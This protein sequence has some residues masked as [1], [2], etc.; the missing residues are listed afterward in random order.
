MDQT[1]LQRPAVNCLTCPAN[2]NDFSVGRRV[3]FNKRVV[4]AFRDNAAVADNNSSKRRA[5][6][7][8]HRD[9][10]RVKSLPHEGGV[11]FRSRHDAYPHVLPEQL[12]AQQGLLSHAAEK[13]PLS[14]GK[15]LA[16]PPAHPEILLDAVDAD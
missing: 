10:R 15:L 5:G 1:A 2:R 7:L 16:K 12:M 4:M 8:I 11:G 9:P 14:N 3:F 13:H 6:A